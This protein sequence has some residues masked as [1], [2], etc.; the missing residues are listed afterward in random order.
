MSTAQDHG[1][2]LVAMSG[3]V[4]SSVAAAILVEQGYEAIGATMCLLRS[5]SE[6]AASGCCSIEAAEDARRVA[7]KLGIRHVVLPMQDVFARVVIKDFVEEYSRG[8]TPNPCLRCNRFV[9]FDELLERAR[10]LG[11]DHLATGHYGRIRHDPERG[12]WLLLRGVDKSKDQSYALYM[13]TQAQL[14]R[15][16][17][18][19]GGWTKQE[20][21]RR[22]A[23]LGLGVAD[24]PDSQ[25]ICFV[26][27]RNYPA[28]L[29]QV[30][31]ELVR[32]GPIADP[33]GKV[34]GQHRGIA[35]YTVGQRKRLGI[36]SGEPRYVLRLDPE[37]NMIV[38]GD[39]KDLYST[40]LVAKD[41]N[42]IATERLPQALA[43]TAKIRYNT[44]D[45]AATVRPLSDDMA[46]VVFEQPQR[47][48]TAGQAVVLYQGDILVGGGTIADAREAERALVSCEPRAVS[49]GP[50]ALTACDS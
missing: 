16:L 15:T 40:T 25:E 46:A 18:P 22:A 8:H 44:R 45:S 48:I 12:R 11:A 19:L 43:V 28:F 32:P 24:K 27:D 36:S 20:T 38:V 50:L 5:P 1:R 10:S 23:E 17:F 34:I 30:A 49:N 31:P 37:N 26:P 7:D 21:R 9:K 41:V 47:A 13:M 3:G 2:V 14:E 6:R 4:D 29:R 39:E 35:F 42:L 33:S